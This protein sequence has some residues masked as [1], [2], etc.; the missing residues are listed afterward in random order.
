LIH[1]ILAISR[2]PLDFEHGIYLT[3]PSSYARV[4]PAIFLHLGYDVTSINI[5]N[6]VTAKSIAGAIVS[7]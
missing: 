2:F 7:I 3:H 6:G 1:I 5:T 4:K